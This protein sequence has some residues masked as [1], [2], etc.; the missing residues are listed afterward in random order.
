MNDT[1]L[2][3][4]LWPDRDAAVAYA[5]DKT[6]PEPDL[7]RLQEWLEGDGWD[8][9]L[10][11]EEHMALNMEYLSHAEF[12]DGELRV[13]E[14]IEDEEPITD[15]MRL[16]YARQKIEE[17]LESDDGCSNPSVA[18]YPLLAADG[19]TAYM[20]C[21]IEIHGQAGPA[22][23]WWGVYETK[24][25]FYKSS[26]ECGIWIDERLN[27]ID[28]Q[29]LL[30]VWQQREPRAQEDSDEPWL[31]FYESHEAGDVETIWCW[32]IEETGESS[33]EFDSEEAALEAWL[34]KKL[35]FSQLAD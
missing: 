24:E 9:L 11:G 27:S 35:K 30:S 34:N 14:E 18:T 1:S 25:D 33:Q 19:R 6:R 5:H 29:Y 15:E 2:P 3:E 13:M 31:D 16:R 22:T 21:V 17:E 32:K 20:G 8:A 28:D 4:N 23:N 7:S 12:I 10:S 26:Q